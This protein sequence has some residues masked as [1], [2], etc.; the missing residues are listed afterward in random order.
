[1]GQTVSELN[2][3]YFGVTENQKT[4]NNDS[5]LGDQDYSQVS[6]KIDRSVPTDPYG[7]PLYIVP[8]VDT[9]F[10]SD[11]VFYGVYLGDQETPAENVYGLSMKLQ[12]DVVDVFGSDNS[13]SFE[14]CWLG[15]KNVDMIT[16]SVPLEDG[17]DIGM[18]RID[19]QNRSGYGFLSTVKIIIPDNLGEIEKIID[20]EIREITIYGYDGSIIIPNI[21]IRNS[22]II[23]GSKNL[24]LNFLEK[25]L[26]VYPNPNS[27]VFNVESSLKLDK[28]RIMDLS[29]RVIDQ[30]LTPAQHEVVNLS[31]F[32]K[33]VYV[34]EFQSGSLT[35]YERVFVK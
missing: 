24:E 11:S 21:V 22:V 1:M 17:I 15:T 20:L 30:L 5:L 34:I 33:G 3:N 32:E 10:G 18:A 29:G 2:L 28:I 19:Q 26:K 13:A 25:S 27:G 23:V 35:A 6:L 9:V 7:P 31:V 14:G 16:M 12:H 8:S 4:N